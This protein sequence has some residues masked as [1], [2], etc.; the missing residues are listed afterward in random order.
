[1]ERVRFQGRDICWENPWKHD[2]KG[3]AHLPLSDTSLKKGFLCCRGKKVG[4]V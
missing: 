3:N 2:G 1:M 4:K